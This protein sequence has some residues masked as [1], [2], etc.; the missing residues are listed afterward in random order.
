MVFMKKRYLYVLFMI[1]AVLTVFALTGCSSGSKL[2][3]IE[4][5]GNKVKCTYEEVKHDF[6]VCLPEKSEDAPLVIILHGSGDSAENFRQQ[7]G[8]EKEANALG[9]A[10]CYITGSINGKKGRNSCSWN[11]GRS[12]GDYDDVGFIKSVV[13]YLIDEYSLDK[14]HVYCA[15]FS[16]GGFMNFRLAL[17]AQ[18]VFR[19]CVSVGGDLC[20]PLWKTRPEKNDVSMLVVVGEMDESV[21]KNFDESAKTALDPA[22]EDVVEYMASS[23]G[24]ALRGTEAVGDGSI[25][26]KYGADGDKDAVWGVLVAET[27]HCWPTEKSGGLDTNKLVLDFYETVK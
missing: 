14:D 26:Q 7:I 10:V 23:N 15:G 27:K 6:V 12:E 21:P 4:K 9:Y 8:F 11:Y 19:A 5:E 20:K 1:V 13:N 16:N 2:E 18:D 17:E 25:V 3:N 24:L 22:I